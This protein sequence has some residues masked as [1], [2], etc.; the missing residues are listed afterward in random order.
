MA[1][2]DLPFLLNLKTQCMYQQVNGNES[3]LY[4][5]DISRGFHLF[6]GHNT[7]AGVSYYGTNNFTEDTLT[8]ITFSNLFLGEVL[9]M[10]AIDLP[11]FNLYLKHNFPWKI[12]LYL[13]AQYVKQ[14]NLYHANEIDIEIGIKFLNH[15]R[16]T[17]IL[18]QI[19]ADP[20]YDKYHM[21]RFELRAAF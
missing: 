2:F 12:K 4:M 20:L 3:L 13:K 5:G 9:R 18:S 10:D 7:H 1:E 14:I 15:L 8:S 21:I 11:A 6:P 19:D 17:T 16:L